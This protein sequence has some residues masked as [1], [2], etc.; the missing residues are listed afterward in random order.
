MRSRIRT[1]DRVPRVF[2]GW[3]RYGNGR[4]DVGAVHGAALPP[5]VP[6]GDRWPRAG[7]VS[8]RKSTRNSTSTNRFAVT[9][10]VAVTVKGRPRMNI[11]DAGKL[12]R[13]RSIV[14]RGGVGVGSGGHI[15]VGR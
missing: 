6:A 7:A 15:R 2:L 8:D 3:A 13:R 14:Q 12:G 5:P 9:G 11:D 10:R 4:G 1:R